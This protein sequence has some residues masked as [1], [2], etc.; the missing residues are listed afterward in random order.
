[1]IYNIN[2]M[3]PSRFSENTI[4]SISVIIYIN[5]FKLLW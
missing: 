1:M 2:S 4:T 3:T 5:R